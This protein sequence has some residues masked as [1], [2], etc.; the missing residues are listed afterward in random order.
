MS[1]GA[2][3]RTS[4]SRMKRCRGSRVPVFSF[5]SENAPAPPSPNWTL[6]ER[7]STPED[8]NRSTSRRRSSTVRPRSSKTGRSPARASTRA[9][10]SPAGPAPTT[11]GAVSGAEAGTG[12]R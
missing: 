7:S 4:S 6:L 3:Q 1:A 9:Q 12:G 11:T 2:P 5:P 8:Q 10:K